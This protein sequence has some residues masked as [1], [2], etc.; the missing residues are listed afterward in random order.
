MLIRQ[1]N[2]KSV[3]FD[4]IDISQ[5]IVLSF[6]QTSVIDVIDLMMSMSFSDI[7]IL[8]IKSSIAVLLV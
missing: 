8:N 2:Q 6:N 7:A 1:G 5:I 4:T 3:V